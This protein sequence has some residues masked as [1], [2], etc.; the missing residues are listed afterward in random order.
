MSNF[1]KRNE[2]SRTKN[3][4]DIHV[5][6]VFLTILEKLECQIES[7]GWSAKK[8]RHWHELH[9]LIFSVKE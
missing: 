2:V 1:D 5:N 8:K 7:I 9:I 4:V 3:V 6:F